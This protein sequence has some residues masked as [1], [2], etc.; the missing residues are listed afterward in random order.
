MKIRHLLLGAGVIAAAACASGSAGSTQPRHRVVMEVSA[1]DPRV[2]DAVLNNIE[3]LR[4]AL[5]AGDTEIE[6][7]AHGGA[8]GML[9]GTNAAQAQRMETFATAGVIF[10]ACENTMRRKKVGRPDLLPF[11][12]TV[13]SGVAEVVRKQERGWSYVKSGF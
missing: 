6:L 9:L 7:V 2:W 10:A 8:L 4:S 13:D 11:A 5:G 1:D 3:N 12:T